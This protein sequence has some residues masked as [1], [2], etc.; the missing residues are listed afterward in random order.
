MRT[1]ILLFVFILTAFSI[2]AQKVY[3]VNYASQADVKVYVVNYES[4]ADLLVYKVNFLQTMSHKLKRKSIM[5][6]TNRKP[7]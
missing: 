2:K 1:S 4:Q 5:L 3:A 6:T 7:M